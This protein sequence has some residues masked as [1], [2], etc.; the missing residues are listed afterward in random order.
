M[1]NVS[2]SV[3]RPALLHALSECARRDCIRLK[4]LRK[5]GMGVPSTYV[6]D[7]I[8]RKANR[9]LSILSLGASE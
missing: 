1:S 2:V 3:S 7:S 9:I 8:I 4:T 6:E 5:K